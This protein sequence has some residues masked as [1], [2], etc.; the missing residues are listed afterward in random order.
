LSY[1]LKTSLRARPRGFPLISSSRFA[2]VAYFYSTFVLRQW[3][4]YFFIMFFG[5]VTHIGWNSHDFDLSKL[6]KLTKHRVSI[7][8]HN[9]ARPNVQT[10]F[11]AEFDKKS[12]RN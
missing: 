4:F 10:C 8:F 1:I 3:C 6:K 2:K 12:V 5:L 7:K 11:E 9:Y